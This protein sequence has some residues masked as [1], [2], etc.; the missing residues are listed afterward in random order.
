[1]KIPEWK[2][3]QHVSLTRPPGSHDEARAFYG[4]VLGLQEIEV[5]ASLRQ[6]DLIWY[7]VG[8]DEIHLVAEENPD[9]TGSARHL[10]LQVGDLGELRARLASTGV[11]T[12]NATPI[13]G[14]PRLF[15][16]D[17]FGNAI[18]LTEINGA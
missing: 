5:P 14:R 1:M 8:P 12:W 2:R 11:E 13:P 16:R 7:A 18:E 10:C 4:D 3:I 17:P 15:C 9:N 6:N